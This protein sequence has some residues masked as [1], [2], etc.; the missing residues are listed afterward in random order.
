[1]QN[2]MNKTYIVLFRGINVGGKNLVPMKEMVV[3]LEGRN[4]QNVLT[5]IQSGN[6]VLQSQ[7]KPED[8]GSIIQERFGFEPVVIVLE[9]SDFDAAVNKNPYRSPNGK[10]IHFF[11]CKDKPKLDTVKLQKYK[12]ESEKYFVD[13]KVFYFFAPDG[14]GRSKLAAK[15]ESCLGVAAT[16]RNFNTINKLQQMAQNL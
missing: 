11:F 16:G 9:K 10:D 15:V 7:S 2:I 4:Y 12:S 1:M 6:V 3:A 8:I 5:Y 14:I 13:G